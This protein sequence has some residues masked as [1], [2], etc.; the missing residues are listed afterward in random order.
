MIHYVIGDA[1]APTIPGPK[2][3]AHCCND[4]GTWGSGFV[5][6]VSKRWKEPERVY[7][8]LKG[9]TGYRLGTVSFA[10][11]EP[12]FLVAN[13]VGQNRTGPFQGKQPIRYHALLNGFWAVAERAES[14]KATVHMPRIGCDRAGGTW[15]EVVKLIEAAMGD[16]DVYV[17]DLTTADAARHSI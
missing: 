4:R 11:V 3:L 15:S 13:I 6:A 8:S 17:Y 12:G 7:R 10:E 9:S 2:I 5:L 1:T 16:L 14:M